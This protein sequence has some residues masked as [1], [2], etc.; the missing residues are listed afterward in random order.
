[1]KILMEVTPDMIGVCDW[2]GEQFYILRKGKKTC[3]D[4]CRKA[5]N[6]HAANNRYHELKTP[7]HELKEN[8]VESEEV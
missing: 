4:R 6:R 2:C 1:M 5:K 3:S 8:N 7:L